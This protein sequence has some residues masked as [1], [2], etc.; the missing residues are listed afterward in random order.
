MDALSFESNETYEDGM[1]HWADPLNDWGHVLVKQGNAKD[2]PRL[3][4][5]PSPPG[6][7]RRAGQSVDRAATIAQCVGDVSMQSGKSDELKRNPPQQWSDLASSGAI[8]P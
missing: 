2:A 4:Q 1:A 3:S 5:E 8:L 6:N 7:H